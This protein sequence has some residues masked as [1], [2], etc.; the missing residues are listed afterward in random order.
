MDD[1]QF[2]SLVK[3]LSWNFNEKETQNDAI[4]TLADN[5]NTMQLKKLIQPMGKEYWLNSSKVLMQIDISRITELSAELLG[6]LQDLN[7]PGALNILSIF[8][9][10]KFEEFNRGYFAAINMANSDNDEIWLDNLVELNKRNNLYSI[11]KGIIE[12][13]YHDR[14]WENKYIRIDLFDEQDVRD[15][16]CEVYLSLL[17]YKTIELRFQGYVNFLNEIYG[18]DESADSRSVVI[19]LY[20][21]ETL[22]RLRN[23]VENHYADYKSYAWVRPKLFSSL[24]ELLKECEKYVNL[25]L[26]F[27]RNSD[28]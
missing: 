3:K 5:V 24:D 6:W 16:I 20:K 14:T 25:F 9:K 21:L 10:I 28:N 1:E 23:S 27:E 8:E 12:Y 18:N 26:D 11:L 22:T 2:I 15:Y 4:F 7:W 19:D 17:D 13:K